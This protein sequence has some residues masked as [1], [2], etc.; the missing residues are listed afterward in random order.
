MLSTYNSDNPDIRAE[1][2]EAAGN[3]LEPGRLHSHF[4][5]NGV[6]MADPEWDMSP[7]A[8]LLDTMIEEMDFG[9]TYDYQPDKLSFDVYGTHELW[10]VLLRINGAVGRH[11]FRGPKLKIVKPSWAS[12]LVDMIRFGVK[13]A[14]REDSNGVEAIGN[15]TVRTV[16]A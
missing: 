15:L 10:I 9:D 2:A 3:P 5:T 12:Q 16:Y 4:S 8:P 1:I 6:E 7:L 14:E 13:R 11:E